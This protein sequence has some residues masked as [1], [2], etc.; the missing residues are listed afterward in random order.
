[1]QPYIPLQDPCST[2]PLEKGQP[3]VFEVNTMLSQTR[4]I[5]VYTYINTCGLISVA[6]DLSVIFLSR[7]LGPVWQ[8]FQFEVAMN[9]CLSMV[10]W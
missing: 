7:N 8:Q 4:T 9:F 3:D 1:M 6:H 5:A 10:S 2:T